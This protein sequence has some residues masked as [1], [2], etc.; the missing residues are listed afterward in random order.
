MSA[1]VLIDTNV[2]VYAYDRGEPSEQRALD[3]LDHLVR[4]ETGAL[5]TQC[6]PN[7]L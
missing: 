6:C 4:G 1:S 5:S 7:G 2:L 3:V